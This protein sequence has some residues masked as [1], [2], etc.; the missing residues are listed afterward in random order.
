MQDCIFCKIASGV[1]VT[2]KLYEDDIFFIVKDIEPKAKLH[3]LAIPK[4]HYAL[5]SQMQTND[6]ANL[7]HIVKT[8]ADKAELLGFTNGYRLIVNQGADA[9]QTVFHLHMHILGGQPMDFPN[10]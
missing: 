10:F 5:L 9:G 6:A 8:I 2:E 3:Y 7:G 4:N 1:I